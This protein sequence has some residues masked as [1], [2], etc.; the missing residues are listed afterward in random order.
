M[1]MQV[2]VT[3]GPVPAIYLASPHRLLAYSH[4]AYLNLINLH[5]LAI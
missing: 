5:T 2:R 1:I 3:D 4:N